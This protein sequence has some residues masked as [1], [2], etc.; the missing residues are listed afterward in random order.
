[1]G[2]CTVLNTTLCVYLYSLTVSRSHISHLPRTVRRTAETGKLDAS[3]LALAHG[4]APAPAPE[5]GTTN[6]ASHGSNMA[7]RDV[8]KPTATR[9][10]AAAAPQRN[11]RIRTGVDTDEGRRSGKR[12]VEP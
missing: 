9:T 3:A 4:P 8:I 7:K 5:T 1:M 2:N 10:G 11:P 6:T 12:T